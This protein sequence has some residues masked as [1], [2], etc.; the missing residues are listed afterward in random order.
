[1]MAMKGFVLGL[2]FLIE[3]FALGAL[4]YAGAHAG[5]GAV[6]KVVLGA[7][8]PLAAAVIWGTFVAPKAAVA[9]PGWLHLTLEVL[10]LGS[11]AAALWMCG[12]HRTAASY[13]AIALADR[14][15]LAVWKL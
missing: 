7:G 1:M 10:V 11:A 3:L 2:R 8:L 5:S 15:L 12:Q 9:V 13:A 6:A 14:V 4:G